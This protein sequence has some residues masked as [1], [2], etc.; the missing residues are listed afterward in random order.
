MPLRV[1]RPALTGELRC[2]LVPKAIMRVLSESVEPMRV[3]DIHAEVEEMLGPTVSPSA[4][5][6]WLAR[7]V[8][9]EH[10]LLVRLKRGRYLLAA[11]QTCATG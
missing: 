4:V 7:H 2:G 5:K 6:N 1:P 3:R 10:A 11:D 8:Q 9:D